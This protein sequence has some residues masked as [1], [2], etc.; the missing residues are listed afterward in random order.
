MP[1]VSAAKKVVQQ[2]P[3]PQLYD[4]KKKPRFQSEPMPIY[5]NKCALEHDKKFKKKIA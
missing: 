3:Q 5:D 1:I 2:K 4:N